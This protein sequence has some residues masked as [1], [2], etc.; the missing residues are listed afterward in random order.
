MNQQTQLGGIMTSLL[1]LFGDSKWFKEMPM[2]AKMTKDGPVMV[3][4]MW[5]F[6]PECQDI[7]SSIIL[8]V[9]FAVFLDEINI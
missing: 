5:Q 6:V 8:G 1:A 9:S 7:W 2:G 4:F 3:N